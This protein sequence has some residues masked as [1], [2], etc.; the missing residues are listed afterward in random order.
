MYSRRRPN[1]RGKPPENTI[2]AQY[3]NFIKNSQRDEN[4]NRF[5]EAIVTMPPG[6]DWTRINRRRP[7]LQPRPPEITDRDGRTTGA[8]SLHVLARRTLNKHIEEFTV[9]MLRGIPWV[10]MKPVWEDTLNT[11][12]DSFLVWSRFAAVYG[13]EPSFV[14]HSKAQSTGPIMERLRIEKLA[15]TISLG[16]LIGPIS[17]NQGMWIVY[18]N[19]L[20]NRGYTRDELLCI[21]EIPNLVVLNFP[22]T[23][24]GHVSALDDGVIRSWSRSSSRDGKLSKL[25]VLILRNHTRITNESPKYLSWIQSLEI[26]ELTGTNITSDAPYWGVHWEHDKSQLWEDLTTTRGVLHVLRKHQTE[27][28]KLTLVLQIGDNVTRSSEEH[29]I[30]IFILKRIENLAVAQAKRKGR[31]AGSPPS[32]PPSPPSGQA[33]KR[34]GIRDSKRKGMGDLLAEFGCGHGGEGTHA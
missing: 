3:K 6:T 23:S 33:K 13:D 30:N 32:S 25:K 29:R 24:N 7:T 15:Y 19:L 28:E 9:E 12:R 2:I 8:P 1:K 27:S 4:G 10:I 17:N 34:K 11:S 22:F 26:I 20:Y 31:S 16:S 5:I 18:L 21:P 14:C